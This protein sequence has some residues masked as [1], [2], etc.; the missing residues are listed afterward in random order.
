LL[1]EAAADPE[2]DPARRCVVERTLAWFSKCRAIH[3]R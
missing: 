3:V 1:G 2:V